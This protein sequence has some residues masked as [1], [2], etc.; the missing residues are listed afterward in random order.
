ME[1]TNVTYLPN[2]KLENDLMMLTSSY[3]SISTSITA[4]SHVRY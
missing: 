2:S 4:F 3:V 1:A